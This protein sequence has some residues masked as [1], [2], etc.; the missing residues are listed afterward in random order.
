M[1]QG[2]IVLITG[3]TGIIGGC[4]AERLVREEG[5]QVRALVRSL[6]KARPLI[7]LGCE[8]VQGD[9]TDPAA[10]Q[11]AWGRNHLRHQ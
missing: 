10:L 9:I 4:L 11:R 3:A 7:D 6:E 1:Q 2:D 8:I 5:V